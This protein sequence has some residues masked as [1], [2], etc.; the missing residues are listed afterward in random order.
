MRILH[1]ADWHVGK[2]LRRR[3]RLDEVERVLAEVV[4]IAREEAV[5]VTLVCGDVFDHF[6]PS[7]EAERIVYATLLELHAAG[8]TVVVI[9]GNHDN[10]KRFGAIE[11]LSRAAGIIV[12]PEVRRPQAG[13]VV[14]L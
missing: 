5:D 9:P 12:V 13:G 10:A 8:G 6:A 1:T 7:A 11:A 4:E 3:Q 2:T 14:E